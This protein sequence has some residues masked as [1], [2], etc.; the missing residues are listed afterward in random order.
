MTMGGQT[1]TPAG[2]PQGGV[3]AFRNDRLGGRLN[4]ILTAMRL[5]RRYDL[6]LRIFWPA[7][8][9]TSPELRSPGDLFD[10]GFMAATFVD[11][12]EGMAAT[13]N[14]VEL[15]AAPASLTEAGFRASVAA[16][17]LYLSNSATEQLRLPF[18]GPEVLADLPDLLHDMPFTPRVREMIDRIDAILG[19]VAFRSYHL[20]R[21]DIIDDRAL[22]SHNLWPSKYIPRVIY[23]WHIKRELAQGDGMIVVF[24]DA[25]AEA[26][27]FAALSPRVRS[28][29][30]LIGD[31]ALTD[32]QRDFL[33]LYTMSRSQRIFAPPSSA[34]SGIAAVI[35]N[36][37]VTDIEADLPPAERAAAMDELVTRLEGF[38]G[39]FLS[40]SDAG[41]NFPF[42]TDHLTARGEAR[43]AQAIIMA[44]VDRG[45]DRAYV[46][47]FLT[48]R[49]L[50]EGNLDGI[51]RLLKIVH[52]RPC[53]RDEHWGE[54]FTHAALADLARG[55]TAR[56]IRH[57]HVGQWFHP[58]SRPAAE[59]FWHMA[60]VGILT[61]ETTYPFDPGLFRRSSRIFRAEGSQ[62]LAALTEMLERDG[63]QPLQ[64]PPG[65]DV[66]DWKRLM[67]KKLNFTFGNRA[68]IERQLEALTHL[69]RK[70]PDAPALLSARG[71]LLASI[72]D[73]P[74]AERQLKQ[75]LEAEPGQPLY[76]KRLADWHLA[77]GRGDEALPLLEM[78]VARSGGHVCYRA[79]LALASLDCGDKDRYDQLMQSVRAD[80]TLLVEL[81]L[82]VAEHMRRSPATLV[83]V[84]A[85]LDDLLDLAPGSQRILTLKA[86]AFEQLNRFD[87]ALAILRGLSATGRQDSII[88]TKLRG[89][90]DAFSRARD[91]DAARRWCAANGITD[92]FS[93]RAPAAAAGAPR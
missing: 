26:R 86:K 44:H 20:R 81:R 74:A 56:A 49:M 87:E 34:F 90:F 13:R 76:L 16:G 21:G 50:D 4:A 79:D 33:E 92:D 70:A 57:Y 67:G 42:I 51:D 19:G 71:R 73:W 38:S 18:E 37:R 48:R 2:Q 41:Q 1:E 30:D 66:R 35:G 46:Y 10:A 25:P 60:T 29:A 17:T 75:A 3:I 68:K 53:Y 69:F 7:H 77:T 52:D 63:L 36:T 40:Q 93:L 85:Y 82:L 22:A 83:D 54:V 64:Y 80:D 61:P 65:L 58:I 31:E 78:A 43:R 88:R 27:A 84:P 32:L 45:L 8:E 15:G 39:A 72:E 62:T 5:A 6:P 47:P 55:R 28:F 14:G 91:A 9:D 12:A 89:L 59:T 24:S 11:K 23:E